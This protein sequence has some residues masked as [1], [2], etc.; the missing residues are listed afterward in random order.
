VSYTPYIP[1]PNSGGE[2]PLYVFL[3]FVATVVSVSGT[4]VVFTAGG[5]LTD[6]GLVPRMVNAPCFL[7]G[8][9]AAGYLSGVA[10]VNTDGPNW[11]LMLSSAPPYGFNAGQITVYLAMDQYEPVEG[12][13]TVTNYAG[14]SFYVQQSTIDCESSLTTRPTLNFTIF[15][16][17]NSSGA[18]FL[19]IVGMPCILVHLVYG[20]LFGGSV[21]QVLTTNYVG[22]SKVYSQVQCVSWDQILT[23]RLLMLTGAFAIGSNTDT[24]TGNGSQQNFTLSH[25]PSAMQSVTVGGSAQSFGAYNSSADWW[26]EIDTYPFQQNPAQTPV[27]SGVSIVVEYDSPG[28]T[29]QTPSFTNQTAGDIVVSLVSLL[30]SEGI[31]IDSGVATG[32]T[33]DMIAF[34]T[35]DTVDSALTN[36]MSYINNGGDNY[37]YYVDPY[38]VFHFDIQGVTHAAPFNIDQTAG[39]DGNALMEIQLQ[40]N[41][42]QM[43]NAAWADI[44]N[45]A[46]SSYAASS[47]QGDGSTT[48]FT[49]TYAVESP[50][51]PPAPPTGLSLFS[52]GSFTSQTIS[53]VGGP[54]AQWY[55]TPGSATITQATGA[56][57]LTSAQTLTF[58]FIPALS[59]TQ[60][61]Y[62]SSVIQARQ[63]IEGGSGEWDLYI[64]LTNN[65]PELASAT[66]AQ[67]Q[68]EFYAQPSQ[69]V[70]FTTYR[71]GLASGQS[72][73]INI[74]LIGASGSYVIDQVKL[75]DNDGLP[76]W[77]IT[78]VAGAVVGGWKRA[79]V[80]LANLL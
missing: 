19:P 4:T 67:N 2:P 14:P 37:W 64:D 28:Q 65:N 77:D 33:V 73:T 41:R 18:P 27:G 52:G 70:S 38:K 17:P 63:N 39:S 13:K 10:S 6:F 61:Y 1:T 7:K 31:N 80:R 43:G 58:F 16:E 24:F 12:T 25:Y 36:L 59:I 66:V 42:D 15:S 3:G 71:G 51:T 60:L 79:F 46:G 21:D 76:K 5:T 72:I 47:W 69:T 8:P 40:T 53:P 68:A 54:T 74:P 78:A 9:G 22:T 49:A 55:Y 48:S 50:Y 57:P 26:W 56:T 23:R 34:T 29:V 20:W 62:N 44:G 35:E 32:P 11:S 75:T 45:Q 30:Q